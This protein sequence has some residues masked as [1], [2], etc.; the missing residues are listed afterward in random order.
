MQ[1]WLC[2]SV[3]AFAFGG[4]A[5][6]GSMEDAVLADFLA[7]KAGAR[8]VGEARGVD[9]DGLVPAVAIKNAA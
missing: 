5:Q 6:A 3:F 1:S 8:L 9:A 2:A 4:A 7:T